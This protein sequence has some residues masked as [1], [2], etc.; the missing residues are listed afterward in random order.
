M[1]APLIL[2]SS[3]IYRRELLSRLGLD[4]VVA[5]PDVD[6]T[7]YRG[8][9]F[10]DTAIRLAREKAVC[11]AKQHPTAIVIGSDQVAA[12]AG[13]RLDKP[14]NAENALAQLQHQRGRVSEFH[15]ALCL[16]GDGGLCIEETLVTTHVRFRN[17]ESLSDDMLKSYIAVEKPFDCAGAAKSEGLGIALIA[18]IQG[19]DPTALVGLPLIALT[20]LLAKFGV[21]PL[22][23]PAL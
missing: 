18:S 20:D 14:G 22:V 19:P 13:M 16:A 17:A 3:S 9:S 5:R 10:T 23:Q 1:P 8:E 4:F 12:C 11:V 2:A 6:E 7:P 21:T 15:T